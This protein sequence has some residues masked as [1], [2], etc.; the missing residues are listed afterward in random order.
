MH[1]HA[2]PESDDDDDDDDNSNDDDDD[3]D[4]NGDDLLPSLTDYDWDDLLSYSEENSAS[5]EPTRGSVL[6]NV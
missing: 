6:A 4:D 5:P 1:A 3:D 2:C